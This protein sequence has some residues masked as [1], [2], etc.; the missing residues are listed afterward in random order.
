VAV[1][2][3]GEIAERVRFGFRGLLSEKGTAAYNAGPL[4]RNSGKVDPLIGA[5]F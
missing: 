1:Q 5:L 3:L 2:A 4:S